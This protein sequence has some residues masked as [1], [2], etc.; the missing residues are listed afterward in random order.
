MAF[1]VFVA[2]SRC[3][4]LLLS[5]LLFVLICDI[6]RVRAAS[7]YKSPNLDD[8][9]HWRRYAETYIK[10]V[11]MYDENR[12]M[13]PSVA[14]NVIIFVGDGMGIASLSTGRIFK[15]QRAGNSGEEEQLSFDMFPNTGMSK[16][17][18][19]DRQVPDSA[20]T[21]T[22]MFSGVKTKYGVVGVDYTITETNLEAA[23]VPSFMEWAQEEGKRTGIVTTTRITHATPAACYAHTINRNY[24]CDEK[25]PAQMKTRV[26]DIARQMIEEAPGKDMN[27][28]LG[29][30]RNCFGASV[31][32][33]LKTEYRFQGAMEK[34]CK[35]TDGRNLVDEWLQRWNGTDA[36]YAWKTSDLRAVDLDRV[37]HLLGLF[38]DDHMSYDT[39]RDRS[40]DGQPSLSEMTEAAIKVLQRP[41]T[42]G[43][44]LMVEGGRIDHAHHQNHAH[45]ALAEVVELDK[46][47]ETALKMVDLDETLIIVT[48][49]HSH[50]MT[51]NGYP[52]RGN[53]ILG[54][55]NRPNATQYETIT[56][57]NGPGFLQHR[58]NDTMLEG[59][60]DWATWVKVDQLNRS[61]ITYRHLSAFP[62]GDETHGGE[63][64][65]VFASGPG[66]NLVRGTFEQSYI[67]HVMSYAAC[68]GP[69]KRLN[70]AC[71]DDFRRKGLKASGAARSHTVSSIALV[72]A[73]LVAAV[74]KL[75]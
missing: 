40:D 22:A 42:A 36:A 6:D 54:F 33:H 41:G 49:D 71:D 75:F 67:A 51:F 32:T 10:K 2:P 17:Y 31:P 52:D 65:A 63:D 59:T 69:T 62:L 26:K 21:A 29:G 13:I 43:F 7:V 37:E 72:T 73:T 46:A 70:E 57:A 34:T 1:R 68:M 25:V 16:T 23:K 15:G 39:V 35:R 27:V 12:R 66:S 61:E 56:Y 9:R 53:D 50:A 55:G 19:T 11:L 58:W 38:A 24:E 5:G 60:A 45:L 20:G 44:A 30:G 3:L 47:V 28:I 14:K 64:V 18:N 48:A 4:L 8:A 74:R